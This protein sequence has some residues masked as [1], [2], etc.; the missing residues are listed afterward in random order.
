MVRTNAYGL[1]ATWA[2]A[3][4]AL[5]WMLAGPRAGAPK[6]VPWTVGATDVRRTGMSTSPGLHAFGA[7]RGVTRRG[8]SVGR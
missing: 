7:P 2:E 5:D 3:R 6:E 4:R 1:L 8:V